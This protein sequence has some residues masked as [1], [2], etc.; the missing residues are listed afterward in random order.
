MRLTPPAACVLTA[1]ATAASVYITRSIT[2]ESVSQINPL[3]AAIAGVVIPTYAINMFQKS[4]T[5]AKNPQKIV[6]I[7]TLAIV[8][9][10]LAILWIGNRDHAY[11]VQMA[12]MFVVLGICT[13][14]FVP[15]ALKA[16]KSSDL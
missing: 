12:A 8:L 10:V 15:A 9:P 1:I 6:T 14:A 2:N 11:K 7:A 3:F 5:Q 4:R 16:T 13:I